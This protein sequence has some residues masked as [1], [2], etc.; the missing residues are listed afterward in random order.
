M[1]DKRK[2]TTFLTAA[3]GKPPGMN[4]VAFTQFKQMLYDEAL[5]SAK[6][7]LNRV[8]GDRQAQRMSWM[9]MAVL[10]G[11]GF[12]K[13]DIDAI[14]RDVAAMAQEYK[15]LMESAGQDNS[16]EKL[17]AEAS[18]AIGRELHYLYEDQYPVNSDA[19]VAGLRESENRIY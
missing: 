5:T 10:S 12:T 4:L 9:Y 13:D 8:L 16:D 19:Y 2:K 11:R 1:A 14:E 15:Q 7:E 17:R 3:T 6:N 18:Q